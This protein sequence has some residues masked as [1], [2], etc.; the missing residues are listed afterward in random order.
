M[1]LCKKYA[2]LGILS[3]I[4]LLLT[5][6]NKWTEIVTKGDEI[7][8]RRLSSPWLLRADLTHSL[9][10]LVRTWHKETLGMLGTARC[11]MCPRK[12]VAITLISSE[13]KTLV[14]RVFQPLSLTPI[15]FQIRLPPPGGHSLT[16]CKLHHHRSHPPWM[17][18][19]RETGQPKPAWLVIQI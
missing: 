19:P 10:P 5:R 7:F 18:S 2:L 11:N 13:K 9:I 16:W 8:T 17:K 4:F 6:S 1:L 3:T 14:L 12:D 15:N